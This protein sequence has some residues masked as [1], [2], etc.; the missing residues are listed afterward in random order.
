MYL[1]KNPLNFK[2]SP[3]NFFPTTENLRKSVS[4]SSIECFLRLFKDFSNHSRQLNKSVYLFIW[5]KSYFHL[6]PHGVIPEYSLITPWGSYKLSGPP[7]SPI[8]PWGSQTTS[9]ITTWDCKWGTTV[10]TTW[11][12]EFQKYLILS[13]TVYS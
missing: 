4:N 9:P 11:P 1:K 5:T 13:W 3:T 7:Y 10:Q 6:L 12:C 8:T 2:F